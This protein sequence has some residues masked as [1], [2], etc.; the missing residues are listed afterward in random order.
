MTV[1]ARGMVSP[2]R[3]RARAGVETLQG[4]HCV[5]EQHAES[6]TGSVVMRMAHYNH[7]Q[8]LHITSVYVDV[9]E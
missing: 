5:H 2:V 8:N 9:D 6:S 7:V 4:T 1:T 3:V